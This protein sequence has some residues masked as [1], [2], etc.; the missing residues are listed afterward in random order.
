MNRV[1]I[2]EVEADVGRH[3]DSFALSADFFAGAACAFFLVALFFIIKTFA[4]RYAEHRIASENRKRDAVAGAY[5]A[6]LDREMGEA[7]S[8]AADEFR[9]RFNRGA[10]KTDHR[11]KLVRG[12]GK[13]SA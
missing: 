6:A 11:F 2:R 12:G 5:W 1:N 4:T 3:G 13:E 8:K 10:R 9:S 7:A